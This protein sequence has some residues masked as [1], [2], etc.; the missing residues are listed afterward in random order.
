MKKVFVFITFILLFAVIVPLQQAEASTG[1]HVVKVSTT[2]NVREKPSPKAKVIGSLKNGTVVYV[3]NTAPGG[4]SKIKY[5]NKD[6]YVASIYLV[7]QG[8]AKTVFSKKA[9]ITA[10]PSLKVREKPSPNARVIGTLKKGAVIYVYAVK[11]GGWS[12]I[13]YNGKT[14]YVA[15]SFFRFTSRLTINEAKQLILQ[16]FPHPDT[17]VKMIYYEKERDVYR[18]RVGYKN[19]A[20]GY[21]YVI[22]DPDNGAMKND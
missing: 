19:F 14:A 11:D 5:N 8:T 12:E 9:V 20:Y 1:Y 17:E 15:T 4:W 21:W 22:I 2:L 16:S 18:A 7:Q 3:Y 13:R 10:S 6:G